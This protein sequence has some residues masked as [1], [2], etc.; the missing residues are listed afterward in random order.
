[1]I[2]VESLMNLSKLILISFLVYAYYHVDCCLDKNVNHLIEHLKADESI[3]RVNL[4][5]RSMD[6]LSSASSTI[7]QRV[8]VEFSTTVTYMGDK[9]TVED[10]CLTSTEAAQM[11]AK[12]SELRVGIV[13]AKNHSDSNEEMLSML[14]F[15]DQQNPLVRGKCMII[16]IN[17]DNSTY[18]PFLKSAWKMDFLDLSI[19][20]LLA[21]DDSD[22]TDLLLSKKKSQSVY[23]HNFNPFY[24]S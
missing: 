11:I 5:V 18:E 19:V 24:D 9:S 17:G 8:T 23:I 12:R 16:L 21:E 7:I 2:T 4:V 15:I 14:E 22:K 6:Q 1:M 20:E 3:N 13:E 10:K